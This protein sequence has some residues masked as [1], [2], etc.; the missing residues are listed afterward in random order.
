[1][2]DDGP[3]DIAGGGVVVGE[4]IERFWAPLDITFLSKATLRITSVVGAAAVIGVLHDRNRWV[5]VTIAFALGFGVFWLWRK[6]RHVRKDWWA[7]LFY[8]GAIIGGLLLMAS[9]DASRELGVSPPI[10]VFGGLGAV[11]AGVAGL[12]SMMR[13]SRAVAEGGKAAIRAE[14]AGIA[15]AFIA[16]TVAFVILQRSR[17]DNDVWSVLLV[18][19]VSLLYVSLSLLS[20]SLYAHG[21]QLVGPE[22]QEATVH[23]RIV[24]ERLLIS[25]WVWPVV[26]ALLVIAVV[27]WVVFVANISFTIV[28]F[29]VLALFVLLYAAA[30][31][32]AADMA[33]V[34]V[35]VSL[36]WSLA[37]RTESRPAAPLAAGQTVLVAL[38]DSYMSGE[39]ATKFF[40]G[41]NDQDRN[42]CRRAPSAYAALLVADGDDDH[43]GRADPTF[44]NLVFLACSGATARD[45]DA[46]VQFENEPPNG[47]TRL[48][49]NGVWEAGATQLEQLD[50]VLRS[51]R[52]REGDDATDD[53]ER[54]L[55]GLVLVSLGGNDAGFGRIA[56]ACVGPGNCAD[57]VDAWIEDLAV[58]ST[59]LDRV[60]T[61]LRTLIGPRV[62]VLVVQYPIPL[63]QRR[64]DL[65]VMS[66]DEHSA[67][68]EFVARLNAEVEQAAAK[69]DFAVLDVQRAF[70]G[71]RICDTDDPDDW[72]INYIA[73]HPTGGSLASLSN[74]RNWF[75][76]SL[77]PNRNGHTAIAAEVKAWV[78][79]N[80]PAI[81]TSRF[82]L[83]DDPFRLTYLPDEGARPSEALATIGDGA[84]VVDGAG[85]ENDWAAC[86]MG[87]V[88]K[89]YVLPVT[90]F[91]VAVWVLAF[92][93]LHSWRRLAGRLHR[94]AAT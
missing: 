72:Y 68:T 86:A 70:D 45:L 12:M 21:E 42:E 93:L 79:A 13:Y 14:I 47:P 39:G 37:P 54:D 60:F 58:V 50:E 25:G 2:P 18:G 46:R 6:T 28:A 23:R 81:D 31:D 4:W 85:W 27:A 35:V 74:P 48:R 94:A 75:H 56:T 15:I 38:G 87:N 89:W 71:H 20:E 90:V 57:L 55:H 76:N 10:A 64:C 32:G 49:D 41:T 16:G 91:V 82:D 26:A 88:L 5:L 67:L 34:L 43:G 66:Q 61:A 33:A 40:D 80:R 59:H 69:H 11:L 7:W 29:V 52:V 44:D 3:S 17:G 36:S 84:C 1:V 62:P 24:P 53:P 51:V 9:N 92:G 77:H 78:R 73:A 63:A 22:G 30:A 83:P 8:L 65:S 19:A